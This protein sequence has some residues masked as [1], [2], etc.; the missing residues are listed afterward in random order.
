[1]TEYRNIELVQKDQLGFIIIDRPELRNAL[2]KETLN[3]MTKALEDFRQDQSVGCV[4]FTGKGKNRLPQ[5]RISPSSKKRPCSMHS[6]Q[7]ACRRCII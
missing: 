2:D 4:I 1:M 5:E 3:E 7:E 6:I